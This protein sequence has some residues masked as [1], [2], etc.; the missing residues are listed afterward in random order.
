MNPQVYPYLTERLLEAGA[1]DVFI[2]PVVMKKGRPGCRVGVLS[3]PERV[4]TLGEILMAES[5]TIGL[6]MWPV[7]RLKAARE[8]AVM[9][10]EWGDVAVKISTVGGNRRAVPEFEVCR[11]VAG[12]TGKPLPEVMSILGRMAAERF[13]KIE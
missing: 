13:E 7:D 1:L 12:E 11:R 8:T 6:R 5:T 10:T 9:N 3:P 2:T 4:R